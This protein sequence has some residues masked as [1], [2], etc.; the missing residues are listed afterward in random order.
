VLANLARFAMLADENERAVTLGR[1]ALVLAEKLGRDDMRSH[2]L[3]STGVARVSLGDNAGLADLEASREIA[4]GAGGPD[5]LRACGNLASVLTIQGQLQRSAELHREAFE[6]AQEIGYEEPTR[7]LATEIACD[8]SLAGQWDEARQLVD[9]LIR[10]YEVSPFWIQPQTRV[11]R[12]RMLLAEGSVADAVVDA[13]RAVELVRGSNVFQSLCGPYAF[14][15]RLHAELGERDDAAQLTE[16]LLEA[17]IQTRAGYV[18]TWILDAWFAAWSTD[19]EARL[20]GAIESSPLDVPW[21]HVA[22]SL[23]RRDVDAAASTLER[24]GAVSAAAE[25][26]LW[27]GEW[28]IENGRQ[29]EA[30]ALLE[31][32]RSFWRSVGARGYLHRS[33]ALLAAAS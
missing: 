7:W 13:E 19:N 12:A 1:P 27:G 33:E 5:Y 4:R 25:A 28:L 30:N 24:I 20:K 11:C 10:G 14:R 23:M 3:N 32:S 26:R 29:S 18:E 17:W 8:L 15:A 16:E 6:I 9:E 21:I 31:R 2:V 22:T